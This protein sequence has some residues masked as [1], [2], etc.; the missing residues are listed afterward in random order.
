MTT[1]LAGGIALVLLVMSMLLLAAFQTVEAI[2]AR[3]GL[4]EL[5]DSQERPLQE[6]SKTRRQLEALAAGV[7]ELAAAG[8]AGAKAVIEEMRREGVTLPAPKR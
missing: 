2:Q 3:I 8:N 5:R 7:V 6:A 1:R 4:G